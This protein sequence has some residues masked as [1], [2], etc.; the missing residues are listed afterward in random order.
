MY[1]DIFGVLKSM[2]FNCFANWCSSEYTKVNCFHV[3]LCYLKGVFTWA[4][5]RRLLRAIQRDGG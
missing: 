4:L 5:I 2:Q 3:A 1:N